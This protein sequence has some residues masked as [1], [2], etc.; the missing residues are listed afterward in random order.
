MIEPKFQP[1]RNGM[2]SLLV[3]FA[4]ASVALAGI[5]EPAF[6]H[7]IDTASLSLST[8]FLHPFSGI[9][10]LLA[11]LGIGLLAGVLQGRALWLTPLCFVLALAGG[12]V[13]A[14]VIPGLPGAELGIGA[15]VIALGLLTTANVRPPLM[16][17][18]TISFGFGFVHGN[19]HGA[20]MPVGADGVLYGLGLVGASVALHLGGAAIGSVRAAGI[21]RLAGG[22]V[23]I[24][25]LLTM[26]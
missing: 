20:E 26:I 8:G 3:M 11:M 18:A 21:G 15:S 12:A 7:P 17:A 25:G 13:V 24:A 23:G 1:R 6:A 10:H 14:V 22:A 19:A 2:R 9:D 5:A 16:L 4:G